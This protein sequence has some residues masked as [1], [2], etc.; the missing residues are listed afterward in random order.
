MFRN[1]RVRVGGYPNCHWILA[2]VSL[3]N[4][5]QARKIACGRK[6]TS[7]RERELF[8]ASL[9]YN[10]LIVDVVIRS[11]CVKASTIAGNAV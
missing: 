6:S 10:Q 11:P 1:D 3:P 4:K 9:H 5:I 8:A 7:T 2:V